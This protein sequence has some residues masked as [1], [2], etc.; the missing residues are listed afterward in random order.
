MSRL[1]SGDNLLRSHENCK[2][3]HGMPVHPRRNPRFLPKIFFKGYN[4]Q[5][6]Y[7][8][9]IVILSLIIYFLI[10]GSTHDKLLY[11]RNYSTKSRETNIPTHALMWGI[12]ENARSEGMVGIGSRIVIE[13]VKAEVNSIFMLHSTVQ[14]QLCKTSPETI[15]NTSICTPRAFVLGLKVSQ[16]T[17]GWC[18]RGYFDLV[19]GQKG[20]WEQDIQLIL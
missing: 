1:N 17:R 3:A 16:R 14:L 2:W 7:V 20:C 8:A 4:R 6:Y 13:A 11:Q 19:V 10:C 9:S 5:E 15:S 12:V 18:S